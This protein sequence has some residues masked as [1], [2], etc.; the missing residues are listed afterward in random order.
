MSYAKQHSCSKVTLSMSYHRFVFY[1]IKLRLK[2][3]K[4]VIN[5]VGKS[6]S[7]KN[8]LYFIMHDIAHKM[9]LRKLMFPGDLLL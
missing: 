4:A 9:F 2:K 6:I 1:L 7:L 5:A 3:K 8:Q